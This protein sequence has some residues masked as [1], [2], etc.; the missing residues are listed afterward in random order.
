MV[1]PTESGFK[2][3]TFSDCDLEGMA[4]EVHYDGDIVAQLNMDKGRGHCEIQTP[5]RFSPP[6]K[7]F[8]F[9]LAD[10]INALREAESLLDSMEKYK[11][12]N[13]E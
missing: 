13:P 5:S 3:V 11:E 9:P 12:D 6:D 8:V 4:V 1:S 2:I 10:F 7:L